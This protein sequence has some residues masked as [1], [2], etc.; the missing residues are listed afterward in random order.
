MRKVTFH[1]DAYAEMN[2]AGQYYEERSFGLGL[3][4]LDAVEEA[5]EK[6]L[7][8]PAAYQLVGDEVRYK[9]LNRFPYSVLYA[10]E[11]DRIRVVAIA[12]QKR[13]PGYW[14]YRL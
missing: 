8:S 14:R 6:I 4:F 2:E 10:I 9:L 3:S 11:Q 1:E 13:R 7:Q 12:H 5:I